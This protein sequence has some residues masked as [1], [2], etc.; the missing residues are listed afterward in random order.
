MSQ[1]RGCH[2][3]ECIGRGSQLRDLGCQGAALHQAGIALDH[4]ER[5]IPALAPEADVELVLAEVE[6]VNGQIG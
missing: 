3:L 6:V 2:K 5:R 1:G 4:L